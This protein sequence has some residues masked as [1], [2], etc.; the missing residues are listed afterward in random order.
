MAAD[1]ISLILKSQKG[2][3]AIC[4]A[5]DGNC[6]M[7]ARQGEGESTPN[8]I[9]EMVKA[10]AAPPNRHVPYLFI[11]CVEINALCLYASQCTGS[12]VQK[13]DKSMSAG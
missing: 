6:N 7:Q 2:T 5:A 9:L 1:I 3:D 10:Q 8:D 12:T 4:A 13:T 11:V